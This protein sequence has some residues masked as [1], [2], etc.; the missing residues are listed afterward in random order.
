[1]IVN[2]EINHRFIFYYRSWFKNLCAFHC[3]VHTE[4]YCTKVCASWLI[5]IKCCLTPI[6]PVWF[7]GWV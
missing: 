5:Y 2:L 3:S 4:D 1:M 6:E 7:F